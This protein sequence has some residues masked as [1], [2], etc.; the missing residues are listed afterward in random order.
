MDAIPSQLQENAD[1]LVSKYTQG[2][3]LLDIKNV[4]I[5]KM[6]NDRKKDFITTLEAVNNNLNEKE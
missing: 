2:K 1:K 6:V 3:Q 4:I 5:D